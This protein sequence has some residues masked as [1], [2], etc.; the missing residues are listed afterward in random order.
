[1]D[2]NKRELE[3]LLRS[4]ESTAGNIVFNDE[5]QGKLS[6]ILDGF[7]FWNSAFPKRMYA[8]RWFVLGSVFGLLS[9]AVLAFFVFDWQFW[10][11]FLYGAISAFVIVIIVLAILKGKVW[12][13][14]KS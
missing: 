12:K 10:D 2:L 13:F 1:M 11:G 5:N 6:Q 3:K 14:K 9:F 4:Q 8:L 7:Y